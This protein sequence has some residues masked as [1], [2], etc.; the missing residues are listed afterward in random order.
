MYKIVVW[1]C[2]NPW[3]VTVYTGKPNPAECQIH[4]TN[5]SLVTADGITCGIDNPLSYALYRKT[6][7][8]TK[9]GEEWHKSENAEETVIDTTDDSSFQ[10]S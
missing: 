4:D 10:L 3:L 7:L 2:G 8:F 6:T 1:N 5:H 9:R